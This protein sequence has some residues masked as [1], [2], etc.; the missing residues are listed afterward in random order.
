MLASLSGSDMH[1]LKRLRAGKEF[2]GVVASYPIVSESLRWL[3][4]AKSGAQT[5]MTRQGRR[6]HEVDRSPRSGQ[7]GRDGV[8]PDRNGH[9]VMAYAFLKALGCDGNSCKVIPICR[10]IKM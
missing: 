6:P 3:R 5:G 2:S 7:F 10:G 8:H 1:G 9:L 4:R